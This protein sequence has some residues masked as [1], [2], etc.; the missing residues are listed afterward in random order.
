MSSDRARIGLLGEFFLEVSGHVISV[1]RK[2]LSVLAVLSVCVGQTV[3]AG[4]LVYRVWGET[5]PDSARTTLRGYVRRLRDALQP[6]TPRECRQEVIETVLGG[7]RLADGW[8]DIDVHEVRR[9]CRAAQ[10]QTDPI[11]QLALLQRALGLWRGVPFG[12]LGGGAWLTQIAVGLEEELLQLAEQHC[13][14]SIAHGVPDVAAI[15]AHR[16]LMRHPLRESLW[17]C[18]LLGLHRA[19]RT[20]EALSRYHQLRGLLAGELGVAPC[21]RLRELYQ[22]LLADDEPHTPPAVTPVLS[23]AV[24]AR[25]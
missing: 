6:G 4:E 9:L 23:P 22:D 8:A 10:A 25:A 14:L 12:G 2:Q 3:D 17:Y 7:Y 13:V 24:H 21:R 20:A 15:E 1:P 16:H 5:A 18:L 19:G 11:E